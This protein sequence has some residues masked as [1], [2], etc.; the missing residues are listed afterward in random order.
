MQTPKMGMAKLVASLRESSWADKLG[1]AGVVFGV[2]LVATGWILKE[3]AVG[4][5][6][7]IR[8]LGGI[9]I[10][11]G[12]VLVV[13]G[14]S[15]RRA[16]AIDTSKRIGARYIFRTAYWGWPDRVG[17]AGVAIGVALIVPALV[18]QIIFRNSLIVAVPAVILLWGGVFLLIYGRFYGRGEMQSRDLHSSRSRSEGRDGRHL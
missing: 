17:L 6:S 10:L 14:D 16:V 3:E 12:L 7:V 11:S 13:F 4:M 5:G 18:L 1:P 15:R 9:V 8:A 2:V